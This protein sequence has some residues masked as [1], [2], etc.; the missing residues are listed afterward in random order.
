MIETKEER[1]V[2]NIEVERRNEGT[3]RVAVGVRRIGESDL[4][5]KLNLFY[6]NENIR[7]HEEKNGIRSD[8]SN[9]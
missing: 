4:K 9:K 8:K 3:K 6:S 5:N 7:P 2:R 1:M